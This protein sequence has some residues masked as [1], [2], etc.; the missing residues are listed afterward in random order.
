[1]KNSPEWVPGDYGMYLYLEY[2]EDFVL[3]MK[4]KVPDT[5]RRWD[6]VK[7]AWWISDA[8]IDDVNNMIFFYFNIDAKVI[9]G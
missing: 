9:E 6:K 1:M 7:E 3:E 2:N 8:F 4:R 5:E